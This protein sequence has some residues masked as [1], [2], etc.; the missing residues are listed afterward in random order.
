MIRVHRFHYVLEIDPATKRVLF[1]APCDFTPKRVKAPKRK[2]PLD[3]PADHRETKRA[4]EGAE[5]EPPPEQDAPGEGDPA[6]V[7]VDDDA[8]P[9]APAAAPAGDRPAPT[10][11]Q[12][13]EAIVA[14]A[15]AAA[16]DNRGPHHK[17]KSAPRWGSAPALERLGVPADLARQRL[18][19]ILADP[20]CP[21]AG[22]EGDDHDGATLVGEENGGRSASGEQPPLSLS[23][24]LGD[25]EDEEDTEDEECR[26]AA[27][28]L[29]DTP[30]L[31]DAGETISECRNVLLHQRCDGRGPTSQIIPTPPT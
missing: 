20:R 31:E 28:L 15:K 6:G 26:L 21:L 29:D 19:E 8:E 2:T 18:E 22:P 5:A 12:D 17:K 27:E 1:V 14:N 7:P 10:P 23:E 3:A 24:S 25:E 11:A 30:G 4:K 13:P 16:L 9:P